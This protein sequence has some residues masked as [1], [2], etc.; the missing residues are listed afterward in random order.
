MT[1]IM[2]D[3]NARRFRGNAQDTFFP[4]L[5]AINDLAEYYYFDHFRICIAGNGNWRI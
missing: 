4:P 2:K 5:T 3:K 1:R